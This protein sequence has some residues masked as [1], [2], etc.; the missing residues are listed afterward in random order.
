MLRMKNSGVSL[1]VIR[2]TAVQR[3]TLTIRQTPPNRELAKKG[4]LLSSK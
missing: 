3:T 1:N 4:F 2:N